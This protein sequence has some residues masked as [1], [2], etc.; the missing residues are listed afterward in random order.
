[1]CGI[2]ALISKDKTGLFSRDVDTVVS[3]MTLTQL[4]GMQST[5]LTVTNYKKPWQKPRM[6]KALGGSSFLLQNKE[7][8]N[9]DKYIAMEGG[10]AFGHGRFATKGS[11]SAKNAHPFNHKHITLVHNGTINGGLSYEKRENVSEI[12]VDSHALCV[13]IAEKGVVDTLRNVTGAFAVILHDQQEKCIWV[14]KNYERPL[15]VFQNHDRI[16]IMSDKNALEF[17][18]KNCTTTYTP[19]IDVVES[20]KLWKFD[21]VEFKWSEETTIPSKYV[22]PVYNNYTKYSG[23]EADDAWKKDEKKVYTAKTRTVKFLV[24]GYRRASGNE[25]SYHATSEENENVEFKT[26]I[27]APELINKIGTGVV[28]YDIWK[29]GEKTLFVKHRSIIWDEPT[30]DVRTA[31]NVSVSKSKWAAICATEACFVCG[32]KIHENDNDETVLSAQGVVCKDCIDVF[33]MENATKDH[34]VHAGE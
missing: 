1:M 22:H 13:E 23:Y 8:E 11:V 5:G 21:L 26:S 32:N 28:S 7:W 15:H 10:A 34:S 14:A 30:D 17:V 24:E 4:R 9:V 29:G 33:A 16:M 3:M 12:E 25:F 2:W 6:W 19:K 27:E 31:N 18:V 20:N